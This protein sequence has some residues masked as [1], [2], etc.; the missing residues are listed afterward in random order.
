MENKLYCHYRL[1]GCVEILIKKSNL[2]IQSKNESGT[3]KKET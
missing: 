2:K 3:F 1:N